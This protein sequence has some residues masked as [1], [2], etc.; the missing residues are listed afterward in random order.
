MVEP[1]PSFYRQPMRS[2]IGMVALLLVAACGPASERVPERLRTERDA[3]GLITCS[4]RTDGT[5]C[6]TNR[7]LIGISMGSGGAGQI[8]LAHPELFDTVGM[9]GISIVDWAY[10]MRLVERSY[11]GGFCDRETILAH[12]DALDDPSSGAFCGP[13]PGTERLEP[14]G[15]VIEA[16]QD[17]NH[18]Y[19]GTAG[20]GAI[21]LGRDWMRLAFQDI[22]FAYGN[23]FYANPDSPYLPPGVP[24]DLHERPDRERCHP[25]P[26]IKNFKHKEYNPTGE[27]DVIVACDTSTTT[28]TFDPN[29]PADESFE[30]LLAVD[31][32]GNGVRDYAEPVLLM[33]HER[34]QDIGVRPGDDYDPFERPTGTAGNWLYDEGEPFEDTGL[35]GVPDTG[36]YG[37]GN[38]V[39]DYSP[40]IQ[41]SFFTQNPRMLV[42]TMPEDQLARIR[43]Y[44]DAGIRDFLG[45]AGGT[46]WLWGALTARVGEAEAKSYTRFE[47]LPTIGPASSGYDFLD[48]DYQPEQLGHHVYVRY[49]DPDA[50]P[51]QI[52]KG[53]GDHVGTTQQAVERLLTALSFAESGFRVRDRR[54]LDDELDVN[55][56]IVSSSFHSEALGE[57]RSFGIALPPG[58]FDPGNAE[59]RYPVVYFLHGL[60]DDPNQLFGSAILFLGYMQGSTRAE[61]RLQHQSDW[62]KFI[63]VFP[64]STCRGGICNSGT[65]NTNQKGLDGQGGRY[66]DALF[67][68]MAHVES[69]YRVLPPVEVDLP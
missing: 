8:G 66:Q 34:F 6:Y 39:F 29:D 17:F 27:Y 23:P 18:W 13:V 54:E 36:D 43:I 25:A 50:T 42:G 2:P 51:M 14:S 37:E 61:Q 67:E 3:F 41:D 47:S 46:N 48:V 44:A 62:G 52:A 30:I 12:L 19:M 49:G 60:G 26:V 68:L 15:K 16:S 53:D 1:G 32:N 40:S 7:S 5:T 35:D 22:V 59:R 56:H 63:I 28:G 55:R 69:N 64:N 10:M 9:L 38:G 57:D 11:L 45:S 65:F 20:G 31:Y 33:S 58:Y 21:G 4:G 24:L